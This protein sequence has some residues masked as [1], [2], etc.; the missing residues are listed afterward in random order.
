MNSEGN[1]VLA[2]LLD[3]FALPRPVFPLASTDAFFPFTTLVSNL[4]FNVAED[5]YS[6]DV[7]VSSPVLDTKGGRRREPP[8]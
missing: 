5:T 7:A 8:G 2:F 6:D 1:T 3:D 4:S